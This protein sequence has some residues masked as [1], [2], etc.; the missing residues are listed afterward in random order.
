MW[1]P[2]DPRGSTWRWDSDDHPSVE[3]IHGHAGQEPI[4][5]RYLPYIVGLYKRPRMRTGGAIYLMGKS[6]I[7]M[8]HGFNSKLLNYQM[9]F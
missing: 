6:T 1:A 5:W 7:S 4:D 3:L 2:R 9:V 8:G